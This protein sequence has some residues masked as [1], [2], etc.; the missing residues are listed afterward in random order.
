MST[1]LPPLSALRHLATLAWLLAATLLVSL[2]Q[3]QAQAQTALPPWPT[4]PLPQEVQRFSVMPLAHINGQ[5]TRTQGYFSKQPPQNLAA[6]YRQNTPGPW[7]SKQ[8]GAQTVLSQWSAPFFTTVQIQASGTGSKVLV[9]TA[10]LQKSGTGTS[11]L[12]ATSESLMQSLPGDARLL[13]HLSTADPGQLS[14]YY[15]LDTPH[16]TT[17]TLQAIKSWL[18]QRG[19]RLHT[20]G[21]DKQGAQMLQFS[22]ERREALVIAGK[23]PDASNY[24]LLNDV[25]F[26]P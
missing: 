21:T 22:G 11:P 26:T 13:Q 15:V 3:A 14:T 23:R 20:Q 12:G 4:T 25:R 5:L 9:A 18:D 24:V 2:A 8:I 10:A 7:L 1:T 19:Y 17:G 6:W 16:G